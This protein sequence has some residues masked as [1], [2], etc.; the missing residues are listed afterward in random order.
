MG[1]CIIV[2]KK[3]NRTR[4]IVF[5]DVVVEGRSERGSRSTD[6]REPLF[7]L[8]FADTLVPK[9]NFHNFYESTSISLKFIQIC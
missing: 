9:E 1:W 5:D 7:N 3:T 2:D 4:Q 8:C 6:V